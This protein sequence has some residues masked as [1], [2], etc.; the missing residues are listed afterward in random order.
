LLALQPTINHQQ[1]TIAY[2][3]VT[4][5]HLGFRRDQIRHP[6]D[7]F[8]LLVPEVEKLNILGCLFPST[9][10]PERSVDNQV[11]LT[12]FMG[13]SRQPSL[14]RLTEEE[15]LKLALEDVDKLLGLQG[16]PLWSKAISWPKAIPQYEQGYGAFLE[17]LRDFE[18]QNPGWF[19]AG[20]YRDGISVPDCISSGKKVAEELF[21]ITKP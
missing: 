19:F 9:L 4:V 20:N 1:P 12:V 17:N 8:G 21:R 5:W 2:S 6:L 18:K 16:A 11:L 7:G 13:G 10:F 14:T 3:P 15:S